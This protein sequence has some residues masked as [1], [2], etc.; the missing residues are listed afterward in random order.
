[1]VIL[2]ASWGHLGPLLALWVRR[3]DFGGGL[4]WGKGN[5]NWALT[6]GGHEFRSCGRNA[7]SFCRI[8]LTVMLGHVTAMLNHRTI[9]SRLKHPGLVLATMFGLFA[10]TLSLPCA[11]IV[12]QHGSRPATASQSHLDVYRFHVPLFAPKHARNQSGP[13]RLLVH[14]RSRSIQEVN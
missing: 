1:M 7:M 10:T 12:V 3:W 14:G 13:K 8:V 6:Q 11:L 2:E 9:M 5:K 4:G